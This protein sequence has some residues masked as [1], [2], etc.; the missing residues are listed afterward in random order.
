MRQCRPDQDAEPGGPLASSRQMVVGRDL[1]GN[2]REVS[3]MIKVQPLR[4]PM[5]NTAKQRW[6]CPPRAVGNML[7][8]RSR[9]ASQY[10]PTLVRNESHDGRRDHTYN[11]A[12]SA[13][14]MV[15]ARATFLRGSLTRLAV[16]RPLLRL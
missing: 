6:S 7:S 4:A 16:M 12:L 9:T 14:P 1:L 8:S 5:P 15:D 2:A 11:S 13:V 10:P 3:V